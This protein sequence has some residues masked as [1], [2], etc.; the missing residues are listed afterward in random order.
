MII[1]ENN[2]IMETTAKTTAFSIEL[3]STMMSLLT[4][5]IY[6]DTIAAVIREWSTNAVDA[7]L[8]ANM[9]VKFK[10][11]LPTLLNPLFSVRDYG[12][13]LA[14]E[15]ILGLF[16]ALGASTKRES[17]LY[18]GAFGIGRM[19]G[20]AY[21]D[22]FTINSYYNGVEYAYLLAK[23]KGIPTMVSLGE[24]PTEE[25]NG[26]KLTITIK[27]K[28]FNNFLTAAT[29][30]YEFFDHKP[31][32]NIPLNYR[33]KT[34]CLESND[35]I[36]YN[37]E[38]YNVQKYNSKLKFIMGNVVYMVEPYQI[39]L[40]YSNRSYLQNVDNFYFKV[41]LGS[42]SI[43]PGRESL[44]LDDKTKTFI[45][46]IISKIEKSFSEVL[47]NE[48]NVTTTDW[49]LV[50]KRNYYKTFLPTKFLNTFNPKI[51][52]NFS[53][54]G[55]LLLYSQDTVK[56]NIS[57]YK[58]KYTKAYLINHNTQY[59]PID[60]NTVF[61]IIDVRINFTIAVA[62]IKV[63]GDKNTNI[64]AIKMD[65]WDKTKI[66]EHIKLAKKY[67]ATLGNP[68]IYIASD[69]MPEDLS[70]HEP[71]KPNEPIKFLVFNMF[72]ET[73]EAFQAVKG[74]NIINN[75]SHIDYYYVVMNRHTLE[76]AS[77]TKKDL[78][79]YLR[80]STLYNRQLKKGEKEIHIIGIPKSALKTVLTLPNFIPLKGALDSKFK[81]LEILDVSFQKLIGHKYNNFNSK[82]R[83]LVNT[84]KLVPELNDWLKEVLE[85][86][87][88][89]P[90]EF[91]DINLNG[92]KER[93]NLN[94]NTIKNPLTTVK[95]R[96]TYPLL[97]TILAEQCNFLTDELSN[98]IIRYSYLEFNNKRKYHVK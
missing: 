56:F 80:T 15:D 82:L 28:N 51:P 5:N 67:I 72:A 62:D 12:T 16:S 73:E 47:N 18:N 8:A 85:F 43:T 71:S 57:V 42:L 79:L 37:L 35:W 1:T 96:N 95:I 32:T 22:S 13:G 36:W 20:L 94:L 63:K 38:N 31:I 21:T 78:S 81:S 6:T 26:L 70:T 45:K 52:S 14:N 41:P 86:I 53:S 40:T 61:L 76:D 4:K 30:I 58:S 50:I 77:I 27:D 29:N 90:A 3:N 93:F 54:N 34:H 24:K 17:N 23:Q 39:D 69:L 46:K 9:P 64:I 19:A 25:A 59:Y 11:S 88:N 92:I 84:E 60:V 66:A 98:Q 44:N 68:K 87:D 83:K 49:E 55:K 75:K 10:V 97:F 7:C 33:D 74:L 89:N 48:L 2:S 65:K 91:M